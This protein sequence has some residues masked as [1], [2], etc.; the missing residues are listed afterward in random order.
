V[1]VLLK[2]L[3]DGA[4]NTTLANHTP[5]VG[6]PWVDANPGI[7]IEGNKAQPTDNSGDSEVTIPD[8]KIVSVQA[9]V[10]TGN[11]ANTSALS[12]GLEGGG[13]YVLA[14]KFPQEVQFLWGGN[15]HDYEVKYDL[16]EPLTGD[17]T[18]Q[19]SLKPQT[20]VF[21]YNGEISLSVPKSQIGTDPIDTFKIKNDYTG[22]NEVGNFSQVQVTRP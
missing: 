17:K 10:N 15:G 3:F 22:A 18:I 11:L 9:V 8:T 13:S 16:G 7:K 4:N 2:D 5:N 12:F 21:D 6:G 1:T 19:F 20:I 14:Y